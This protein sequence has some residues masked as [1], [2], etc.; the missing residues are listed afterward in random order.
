MGTDGEKV[1]EAWKLQPRT[2]LDGLMIVVV[3]VVVVIGF[4]RLYLDTEELH[5]TNIPRMR[6]AC[7][8]KRSKK[9]DQSIIELLVFVNRDCFARRDS[10][11][12]QFESQ[13]VECSLN[14][15]AKKKKEDVRKFYTLSTQSHKYVV[16]ICIIPIHSHLVNMELI[17]GSWQQV[18]EGRNKVSI[19]CALNVVELSWGHNNGFSSSTISWAASLPKNL[20]IWWIFKNISSGGRL[21]RAKEKERERK[22]LKIKDFYMPARTFD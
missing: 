22:R 12:N 14:V 9:G 2:H 16:Y 6:R 5:A 7:V 3:V 17:N 4:F 18:V 13:S 10:S 19:A 21:W 1:L 8:N 15:C 20:Y 11:D